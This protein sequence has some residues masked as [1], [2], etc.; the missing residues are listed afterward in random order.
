MGRTERLG[1]PE[2]KAHTHLVYMAT[3]DKKKEGISGSFWECMGNFSLF[4]LSSLLAVPIDDVAVGRALQA[5]CQALQVTP[6]S[7][8]CTLDRS[9]S[10]PEH[11][12]N[13]RIGSWWK[14][15]TL[16]TQALEN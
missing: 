4:L 2:I 14:D 15:F 16:P 7:S 8:C 9:W 6:K 13:W 12:E 5:L 3:L 10:Y 1:F 11:G